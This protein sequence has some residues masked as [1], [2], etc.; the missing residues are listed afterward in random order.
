MSSLAA[1]H[2]EC[3]L[4][5]DGLTSSRVKRTRMLGRLNQCLLPRDQCLAECILYGRCIYQGY[6]N[7]AKKNKKKNKKNKKKN[8]GNKS[9]SAEEVEPRYGILME[10]TVFSLLVAAANDPGV[11]HF[12]VAK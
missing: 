12:L 4:L 2:A 10:D 1:E 5:D 8:K 7:L 6:F 11:I 3:K 9:E